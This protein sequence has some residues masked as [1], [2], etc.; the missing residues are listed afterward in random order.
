MHIPELP[1]PDL[2]I[3]AAGPCPPLGSDP[4]VALGPR[5]SRGPACGPCE[6]ATVTQTVMFSLRMIW[7]FI[8]T[9]S[10]IWGLGVPPLVHTTPHIPNE[11]PF[12]TRSCKVNS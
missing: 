5:R 9:N 7:L 8:I 3:L 4:P 12:F 10:R 6:T 1:A 11:R 2:I